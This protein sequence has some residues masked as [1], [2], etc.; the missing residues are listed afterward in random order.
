M[1]KNDFEKYLK[2]SLIR[3]KSTFDVDK[4]IAELVD[5]CEK[6]LMKN[7][8][9]TLLADDRFKESTGNIR[10]GWMGRSVYPLHNHDFF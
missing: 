4:A 1:P 10:A 9:F 6:A 3:D 5:H 7:I 8:S 2:Y